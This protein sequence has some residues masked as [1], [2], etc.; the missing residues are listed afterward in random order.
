MYESI[1]YQSVSWPA[2]T[3][4][5]RSTKDSNLVKIAQVN[6]KYLPPT[7]LGTTSI[8]NELKISVSGWNFQN[9]SPLGILA[10]ISTESANFRRPVPKRNSVILFWSHFAVIHAIS[11]FSWFRSPPPLISAEC[12][13]TAAI[14]NRGHPLA[15]YCIVRAEGQVDV[16]S[17]VHQIHCIIQPHYI[18]NMKIKLQYELGIIPMG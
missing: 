8:E 2:H 12:R 10:P 5:K 17:R 9:H 13:T 14:F 11:A 18:W 16:R 4:L 6:L 7:P 15:Q 1:N 3:L